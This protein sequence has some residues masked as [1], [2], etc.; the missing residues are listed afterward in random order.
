[1]ETSEP[2][3]AQHPGIPSPADSACNH[4]LASIIFLGAL[5]ALHIFLTA[6]QWSQTFVDGSDHRVHDNALFLRHAAHSNDDTL[7]D[8]RKIFGVADY[9]FDETGAPVT[10]GHYGKHGILAPSLFRIWAGILGYK[11]W[12]IHVFALLGSWLACV[13]V[14]LL[15]RV[16]R[17]PFL[18]SVLSTL[19]F[20]TIPVR[21][22]Y[23]D[24][25]KY[26]HWSELCILVISLMYSFASQRKWASFLLPIAILL[27][28]HVDYPVYLFVAAL[29]GWHWL[30]SGKSLPPREV[31]IWGIAGAVGLGMTVLIQGTLG[32]STHSATENMTFRMAGDLESIS[33]L[34]QLGRQWMQLLANFG[35]I[36]VLILLSGLCFS[37][38]NPAWRRHPLNRFAL[39]ITLATLTWCLVFRNHIWMHHYAQWF[40]GL[41][42][43]LYLAAFL[44]FVERKIAIA[45]TPSRAW[46]ITPLVI[47]IVIQA[48][49][50]YQLYHRPVQSTLTAADMELLRES[51]RRLIRLSPE[52]S[53]PEIWW[54]DPAFRYALDPVIHDK[55]YG[56]H[57]RLQPNL[58]MDLQRDAVVVLLNERARAAFRKF[59]GQYRFIPVRELGR[60]DHFALLEI[61]LAPEKPSDPDLK[62][63]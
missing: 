28:F 19:V 8:W 54:N 4:R 33:L 52:V 30:R 20:A 32:F 23:A 10:V 12:V 57:A 31:W 26:E 36:L 58:R 24:V 38:W 60:S 50:G 13:A 40:F 55:S 63:E 49:D 6:G 45:S 42:A 3:S 39:M 11:E 14:F 51:D 53:G 46:V 62:T 7:P 27:A 21:V 37:V 2:E 18:H 47:A 56:F 25:W 44:D 5:L 1:M 35:P 41:A 17:I 15:L 16:H 48:G 9:S 43:V 29:L 59:S 34:D 22:M 61:R